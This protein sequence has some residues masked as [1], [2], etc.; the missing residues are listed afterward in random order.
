M[1]VQFL[2]WIMA[3]KLGRCPSL[4][5]EKHNLERQ[6]K[7]QRAYKHFIYL[8]NTHTPPFLW[9]CLNPKAASLWIE[10]QP[11]QRTSSPG[12]TPHLEDV[13]RQPLMPP[14]VDKATE[15]GI[16]TEN[17]PRSFSPN[18]CSRTG[19]FTFKTLFKPGITL[20]VEQVKGHLYVNMHCVE[21]SLKF[22]KTKRAPLKYSTQC[23]FCHFAKQSEQRYSRQPQHWMTAAPRVTWRRSRRC[24]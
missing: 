10:T 18:V 13:K 15:M 17:I 22:N 3:S 20:D 7:T 4:A 1:G 24:W 12:L 8:K 16:M 19:R 14:N 5:P 9:L 6:M 21:H 23:S 2:K 11:A